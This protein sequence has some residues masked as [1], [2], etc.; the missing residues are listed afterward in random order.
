MGNTA[1]IAAAAT[2]L[3]TC[4]NAV[5]AGRADCVAYPS[6]PLYSLEWTKPYN[7]A[8]PVTPIAVIRP[9]NAQDVSGTIQ[10]ATSNN[11]KLQAKSGGHS[12]A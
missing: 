1:S 6:N 4:L 11:V 9:E 10:C 3:Q 2:P 12:Y 7:L 8:L 5:C